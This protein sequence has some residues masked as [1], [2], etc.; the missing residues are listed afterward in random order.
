MKKMKL[1]LVSIMLILFYSCKSDRLQT[2]EIEDAT[3]VSMVISELAF[4]ENL[5]Q[6]LALTDDPALVQWSKKRKEN[7]QNY[8]NELKLKTN[9]AGLSLSGVAL[10][11]QQLE[12][13]N[14]LSELKGLAL[15]SFLFKQLVNSDQEMI[16]L[17][18]KAIGARGLKNADFREW[19]DSKI[20]FWQSH[21]NESQ[22][23]KL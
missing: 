22:V 1:G 7:I 2:Y 6:R 18:V 19:A 20:S 3:F 16:G 8:I 9:L 4:Q 14:Q 10:T 15:K 17:H 11:V 21:L 23:I 5:N 13:M 12:L